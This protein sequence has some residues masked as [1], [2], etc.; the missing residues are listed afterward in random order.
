MIASE[1]GGRTTIRFVSDAYL[2]R[3]PAFSAPRSQCGHGDAQGMF[4]CRC[5]LGLSKVAGSPGK[6]RMEHAFGGD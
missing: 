1:S 2:G 6:I 5:H 4:P 3:R